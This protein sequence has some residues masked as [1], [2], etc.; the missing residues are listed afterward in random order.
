M[1]V[2]IGT[3][4]AGENGQ[5]RPAVIEQIRHVQFEFK[6]AS[7]R[8]FDEIREIIRATGPKTQET[9]RNC[10]LNV[11]SNCCAGQYRSAWMRSQSFEKSN[12]FWARGS[13]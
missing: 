8:K 13:F 9:L 12:P 5:K 3:T 10:N 4:I 1:V 2:P 6:I 11:V 7:V